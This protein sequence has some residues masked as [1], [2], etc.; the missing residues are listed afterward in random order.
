MEV[1]DDEMHKTEQEVKR[2]ESPIEKS[3]IHWG[4]DEVTMKRDK[5][6][7]LI[8]YLQDVSERLVKAEDELSFQRYDTR[9]VKQE[10][11][12]LLALSASLSETEEGIQRW[13]ADPKNSIQELSRRTGIPYATCHR[14][15]TERLADARIET[16]QLKKL[17][18][19]INEESSTK[20]ALQSPTERRTRDIFEPILGVELSRMLLPK[21]SRIFGANAKDD[22]VCKVKEVQPSVVLVDMT[23]SK[24]SGETLSAFGECV[25]NSGI[26]M[27][28]AT[29]GGI[30]K[31]APIEKILAVGDVELAK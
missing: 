7:V 5:F 25:M 24:L 19:A 10:A 20:G 11:N 1:Q 6:E 16:G 12:V 8:S 4:T 18:K 21:H 29:K 15:V 28:F 3:D 13:L 26:T 17:A 14:I 31:S 30:K 23:S 9:K 27:V 22:L 2:P